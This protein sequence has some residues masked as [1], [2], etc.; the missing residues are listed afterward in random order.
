MGE[1]PDAKGLNRQRFQNLPSRFTTFEYKTPVD[2][3]NGL[4]T[5]DAT[6]VVTYPDGSC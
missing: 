6:V 4:V 1:T 2:T 5:K 3:T